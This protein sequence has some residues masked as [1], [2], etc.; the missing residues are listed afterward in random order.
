MAFR[1]KA[2]ARGIIIA[3]PN[4]S[5]VPDQSDLTQKAF[6]LWR[7]TCLSDGYMASFDHEM[8]FFDGAGITRSSCTADRIE[9]VI[10]KL[11]SWPSSVLDALVIPG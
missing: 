9:L 10:S 4:V 1:Q 7:A 2:A 8:L 11:T 5:S 3:G 6:L